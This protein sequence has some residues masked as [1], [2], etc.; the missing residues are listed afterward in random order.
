MTLMRMPL[1]CW[2]WLIT[3]ILGLLAFAVLLVGRHP[4]AARPHR[5]HQLLHSRR[6]GGER[7][8]H[9]TQGRL[10]AAL[11]APVLVLRTS[12]G[13]HRDPARHGR[14]FAAALHVLAQADLRIQ[15]DGVRHPG[16]RLPRLHG[17]GPSHVHER[18]E[19][20]LGYGL[21]HPDHVHRRAFG[22]QDLQLA[23]DTLGRARSAFRHRMLFA[24]GFVSLF[25]TGGISGIFLASR[26]STSLL[27]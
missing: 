8:D 10:A 11:A 13:V 14:D 17:L 20:V 7:P 19:P 21:L 27:P 23:R 22:D 16:H 4:A 25:V 1:T 12:R 2:T 26:R 15:G 18:H 5:R 24:L 3:A 9:G 6:A